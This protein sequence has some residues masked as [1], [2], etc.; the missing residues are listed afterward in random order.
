VQEEK[1]RRQGP[2]QLPAQAHDKSSQKQE[3]DQ[4]PA[5]EQAPQQ[6]AVQK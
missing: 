2:E 6:V 3:L 4:L 5:Q 1:P